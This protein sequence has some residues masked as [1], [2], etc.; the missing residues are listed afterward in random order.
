MVIIGGG[1]AGLTLARSLAKAELQVVL[2]DK[3]N[4]HTFQ[5]LLYQVATAGLEPDSIAYPLRKILR[6]QRNVIFRMA[7]VTRVDYERN[8]IETNIGRIHYDYLVIATGSRPNYFGDEVLSERVWPLKSIQDAFDLRSVILQRFEQALLTT[9]INERDALKSFVI[10]GGGPTGVELAG[11]L[12][13]LKRHILPTDYPELDLRR[14]QIHVVEAA[15]RLL[16]AMSGEASERANEFL[17]RL[18]VTVWLSQPVHGYDGK[19]VVLASGR[20]LRAA[21]VI[22]TAGVLGS[23]ISGLPLSTIGR[24]QRIKVDHFNR[25][26]GMANVFVIGD[27]ALMSTEGYAQGHPMVAQVAMQQGRQLAK[28]LRRH[29]KGG[30]W[31]PFEYVNFGDLATIGRNR[32]VADLRRFRFQGFF[33]WLLWIFI[34]LMNL[35]GFRNRL[36]VLINWI[37]NY[38]TYDRGIRLILRSF[39]AV[40][41]FQSHVEGSVRVT[42]IE[43]G[44]QRHL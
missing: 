13:E 38:F 30:D 10:V 9:D 18:G 31:E 35:I 24:S 4:F 3:N 15:E 37:W 32:A 1:F 23:P 34:H 8:E 40:S 12:S 5:P 39:R 26:D 43:S 36:I 20:G 6:R 16:P 19:T 44:E 41:T 27:L 7:E 11:A 33:A 21:T 42:E 2:L 29:L 17:V 22:W 28:N 25:V 14:M